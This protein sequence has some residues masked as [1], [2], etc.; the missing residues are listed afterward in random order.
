MHLVLTTVDKQ[1]QFRDFVCQLSTLELLLDAINAIALT[2]DLIIK[3]QLFD[4]GKE[5]GI[6]LPIDGFDGQPI[7]QQ[8]QTLKKQ[9]QQVLSKSGSGPADSFLTQET[10]G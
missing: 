8:L 9:W 1:A 4:E 3:A 10:V 2:S 7:S 5:K 6:E